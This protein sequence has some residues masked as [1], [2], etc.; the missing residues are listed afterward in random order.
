MLLHEIAYSVKHDNFQNS[1]TIYHLKI[2]KKKKIVISMLFVPVPVLHR[3]ASVITITKNLDG[4]IDISL[5]VYS[6]CRTY[7]YY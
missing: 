7:F 5:N 6:I 2:K 3:I 4:I 1:K